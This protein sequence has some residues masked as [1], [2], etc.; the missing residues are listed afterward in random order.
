MSA[1]AVIDVCVCVHRC[2]FGGA[3]VVV[4]IPVCVTLC[5]CENVCLNTCV[6]CVCVWYSDEISIC[7]SGASGSPANNKNP[8]NANESCC[9]KRERGDNKGHGV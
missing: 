5:M 7:R 1:C 2:V 4:C 3:C 8:N 9:L 6:W